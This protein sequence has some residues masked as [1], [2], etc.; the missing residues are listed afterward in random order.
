[1]G[2]YHCEYCGSSQYDLKENFSRRLGLP[3][4]DKFQVVKCKSCGL[5]SLNPLPN[6]SELYDIY[7]NYAEQGDRN[8]LENKRSKKN[9][10]RKIE[11]IKKYFP[12]AETVF[13]IGAGLGTFLD[14][15]KKAGLK[16]T[17]IEL[18]K[19]QVQLAKT[20]YDIDLECTPFEDYILSNED[21]YDVVNLSHVMEH[22]RH[23]LQTLYDIHPLLNNNGLLIIEVPNEFF[24]IFKEIKYSLKIEKRKPPYNSYHHLYFYSPVILQKM[25][26]KAGYEILEMTE[27]LNSKENIKNF[28]SPFVHLFGMGISSTFEIIARSK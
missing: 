21:K 1:M 16:V 18:E 23:P 5:L 2:K 27:I 22:L 4:E 10:P 9:Y 11:R 12:E 6:D 26:K 7:N 17:G 24:N 20:L 14:T 25:I 28:L 13:D 8:N 15:A 19:E 3:K